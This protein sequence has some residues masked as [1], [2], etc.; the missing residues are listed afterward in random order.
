MLLSTGNYYMLLQIVQGCV[1]KM[2]R[3]KDVESFKGLFP[4]SIFMGIIEF[5]SNLS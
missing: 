1:E 5:L 2:S 4:V 3:G